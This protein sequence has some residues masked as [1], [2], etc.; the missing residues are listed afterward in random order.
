[1]TKTE[2]GFLLANAL[3]DCMYV[4]GADYCYLPSSRNMDPSLIRSGPGA[5]SP[6]PNASHVKVTVTKMRTAKETSNPSIVKVRRPLLGAEE[7]NVTD[8]IIV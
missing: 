1:M 3:F 5:C 7:E 6:T 4:V 8:R 2:F